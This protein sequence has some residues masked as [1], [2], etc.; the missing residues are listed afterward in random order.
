VT[1]PLINEAARRL[2]TGPNFGVLATLMPDGS[3]QTSAV[4]VDLQGDRVIVVTTTNTIK[5]RNIVR[6]SRVALTVIDSS[7]P[8]LEL[9]LRGRVDA[10]H[11]EA[12]ISCID[13]LSMRYYRIEPYPYHRAGQEWVAIEIEVLRATTTK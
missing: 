5:F 11:P 3:P 1:R 8:Y 12:G 2:L 6:D 10:L 4:W 13:R 9:S 7:D